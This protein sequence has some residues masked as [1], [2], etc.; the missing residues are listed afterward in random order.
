M[1]APRIT[2]SID[3][4]ALARGVGFFE[5]LLVFTAE[6]FAVCGWI[7][8]YDPHAHVF[9]GNLATCVTDELVVVRL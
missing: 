4:P 2:M 9:A 8:N 5:T 7:L 1:R 6:R 3:A